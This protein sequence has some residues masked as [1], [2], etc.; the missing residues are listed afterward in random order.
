MVIH[1]PKSLFSIGAEVSRGLGRGLWAEA[2]MGRRLRIPFH[3]ICDNE[4][5]ILPGYSKIVE[6]TTTYRHHVNNTCSYCILPQITHPTTSCT[7]A[8]SMSHST[9]VRNVLLGPCTLSRRRRAIYKHKTINRLWTGFRRTINRFKRS[10][11]CTRQSP[12]IYGKN[13]GIVFIPIYLT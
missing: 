10:Q 1:G 7:V 9:T 5:L 11:I 13:H 6:R 4:A 8:R 2:S 3:Q 12:T